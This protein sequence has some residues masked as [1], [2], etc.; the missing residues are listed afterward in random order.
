MESA[1]VGVHADRGIPG[2]KEHELP[3]VVENLT[4]SL[5]FSLN[6][7]LYWWEKVRLFGE[8]VLCAKFA[9]GEFMATRP[10]FRCDV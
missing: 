8:G 3:P 1:A 2:K 6:L 9:L 7:L 4:F 5:L 10:G